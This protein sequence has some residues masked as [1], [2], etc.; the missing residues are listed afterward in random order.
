MNDCR[1]WAVAFE[2]HEGPPASSSGRPQGRQPSLLHQGTRVRTG[3]GWR[4]RSGRSLCSCASHYCQLGAT[5]TAAR[6]MFAPTQPI[7]AGTLGFDNSG[8]CDKTR[9]IRPQT[10]TDQIGGSLVGDD[11]AG[12][13]CIRCDGAVQGLLDRRGDEVPGSPQQAH[14]RKLPSGTHPPTIEMGC[15]LTGMDL[16]ARPLPARPCAMSG[17]RTSR[18]SAEAL[19][20]GRPCLEAEALLGADWCRGTAGL[21]V[22]LGGSQRISPSNPVSSA[23]SSTRS[24]MEISRPGRG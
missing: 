23:M 5:A 6:P 3:Q 9:T 15:A 16:R 19:L 13:V 17:P 14:G 4:R 18:S 2:R 21:A 24:L 10:A 22:G 20:E 1:R 8:A 12:V 7:A 11:P